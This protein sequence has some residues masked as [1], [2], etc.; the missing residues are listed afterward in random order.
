MLTQL[1]TKNGEKITRDFFKM[2]WFRK[3]IVYRRPRQYDHEQ[4][5][6]FKVLWFDWR[7]AY[8]NVSR[9]DNSTSNQELPKSWPVVFQKVLICNSSSYPRP[10]DNMDEQNMK[11][12]K[13]HMFV[14][15]IAFRNISLDHKPTSKQE[16]SKRDKTFFQNISNCNFS[17][18]PRPIDNMNEQMWNISKY[19][20]LFDKS[21]SG[22]FLWT[23]NQLL[24]KNNQNVTR[25]FFK[26]F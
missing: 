25:H 20:C 8:R 5:R 12:F 11:Y 22:T 21:L 6:Y 10:M 15:Q 17:S 18:Y 19:T 23:I 24:N 9:E 2:W 3:L 13:I 26:L 7:I 14:W 4:T 1:L 16:W